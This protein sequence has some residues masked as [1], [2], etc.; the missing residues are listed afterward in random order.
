MKT[1]RVRNIFLSVVSAITVVTGALGGVIPTKASLSFGAAPKQEKVVLLGAE[2]LLNP[3]GD[4]TVIRIGTWYS[5]RDLKNL[6]AYLAKQFP[7]YVFEFEYIDR[8]NYE[9][10]MDAK[11][12]YKGAPDILY[13]DQEMAEKHAA[14]G[15]IENVT[16]I[17][18]KFSPKAKLAFG[19]GNAVYAVPNTS[20]FECIYYNKE[21]FESKGAKVPTDLNTFIGACDYFRVVRN[22]RPLAASLKDPYNF[23][24]SAFA[25]VAA[26]YLYTDRGKGF[27]GRLQYGRTTFK[28]EI[29]PYMNAWEELI[30][31]DILTPDMYTIDGLTAI[32]DFCD[33]RA[34]MIVG[35]PEIYNAII[36]RKPDMQIGTIPFYGTQENTCAMIGGCDLGFALNK[37]SMNY[38]Q[39]KT[40][41][42][43]LARPDGQEA[44]WKD[45]P[46]SQTYLEDVSFEVSD[47]YKGIEKCYKND[48]AFTPWMDWG[49]DLNKPVH[50]KFGR[51]LQKVLLRRETLTEAFVNVDDLV[52]EI[53]H[54][55]Q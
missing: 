30:Y 5:E 19:Y 50:Y 21:M 3:D 54:E 1:K 18:E 36:E 37:N 20:Q 28:D 12:S 11:L 51:E 13:V 39:A 4:N 22:I 26:D 15:Y 17:T 45:R 49:M 9:S 43:S 27:G 44:L 48:L 35:G 10:I 6:K 40:V 31:H 55:D 52:D 25:L 23:A 33:A 46:G 14:T 38:N 53:L 2:S 42:A 7:N 34:A 24:N 8:S 47:V 16:D 41:L 32:E 29:L